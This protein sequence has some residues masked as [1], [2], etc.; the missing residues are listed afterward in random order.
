M[1]IEIV[2]TP[3]AE[4]FQSLLRQGLLMTFLTYAVFTV[5]L[6]TFGLIYSTFCYPAI[7]RDCSSLLVGRPMGSPSR[8]RRRRHQIPIHKRP[9]QHGHSYQRVASPS[10]RHPEVIPEAQ[11]NSSALPP[12]PPF[13]FPSPP[14]ERPPAD[15]PLPSSLSSSKKKR[16]ISLTAS[17]PS[18]SESPGYHTPDSAQVV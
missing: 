11:S 1:W 7:R 9:T 5:F 15:L 16:N 4:S 8:K 10:A 2:R 6:V 12:P 13:S 18:I 14:R 3:F 17:L